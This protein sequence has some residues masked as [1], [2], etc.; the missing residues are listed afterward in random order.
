MQLKQRL[1]VMG[2]P[3]FILLLFIVMISACSGASDTADTSEESEAVASSTSVMENNTLTEAEKAEGWKLLFDGKTTNGW[4][5]YLSD[6]VGS[7]WRIEDD[8]LYLHADRQEDWAWKPDD[9]GFIMTVDEYENFDLRLQWKISDCGNSGIIYHAIE[10]EDYN[11]PWKTGLEMQVLDNKCHPDS[12]IERHRAGDLY[13]L[14]A[15]DPETVRPAGEWNDVRIVSDGNTI[16]HWL[17][18]EKVVEVERYSEAW[19]EVLGKSKFAN[20]EHVDYSPD[21]GIAAKGHIAL[22]DHNDS[23]VWYRN[24]KIKEL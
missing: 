22:Q 2:F 7:S 8:A 19:K 24:I 9:G 1:T 13:D 16:Q 10:S 4:K 12:K 11:E 21:Y 20:P 18:G 15:A 3:N 5:G 23:K 6:T 14:I 17:N